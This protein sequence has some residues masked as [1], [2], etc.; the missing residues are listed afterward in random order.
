MEVKK[1]CKKVDTGIVYAFSEL[2]MK[3]RDFVLCNADG[4]E[5]QETKKETVKIQAPPPSK[6]AKPARPVQEPGEPAT[7]G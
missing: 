1:F 2:L 6:T 5:T 4:S 3:R 7:K